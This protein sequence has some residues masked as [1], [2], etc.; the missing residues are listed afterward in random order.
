VSSRNNLSSLLDDLGG[1][2]EQ[3]GRHF[4]AKSDSFSTAAGGSQQETAPAQANSG[5]SGHT[6]YGESN[7]F[8]RQRVFL[9]LRR[10]SGASFA[11]DDDFQFTARATP[12]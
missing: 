5:A 6:W 12:A 8:G 3:R 1:A 2:G 11:G 4:E 10:S 9:V 7:L